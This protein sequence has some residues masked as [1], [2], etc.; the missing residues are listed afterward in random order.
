[1]SALERLKKAF[2]KAREFGKLALK[3]PKKAKHEFGFRF[4][5][6]LDPPK[7]A[8]LECEN[9]CCWGIHF[10]ENPGE[11][12]LDTMIISIADIREEEHGPPDF[13]PGAPMEV[14]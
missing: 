12:F 1:M 2:R 3:D 9:G 7:M 11:E 13:D 6:F 4:S 10:D 8:V 14:A 5:M